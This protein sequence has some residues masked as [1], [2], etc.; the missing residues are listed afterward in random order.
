MFIPRRHHRDAKKPAKRGAGGRWYCKS[1][2]DMQ[3]REFAALQ[4]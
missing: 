2:E 3:F 4:H 1:W